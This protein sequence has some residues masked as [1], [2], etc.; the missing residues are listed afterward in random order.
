MKAKTKQA[1]KPE[2]KK[3]ENGE[4]VIILRPHLWSGCSGEIVG[5]ENGLHRVKITAKPDGSDFSH[6]H[7]ECP[8]SLLEPY[9]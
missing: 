1:Y 8:G 6:F 2:E 4:T 3:F 5:F 7:C 9:L